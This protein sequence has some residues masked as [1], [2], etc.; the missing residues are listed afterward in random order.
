M[1]IQGDNAWV[2]ANKNVPANLS[3]YGGPY[4][5]AI[6]DSAVQEY[7][8]K[9]GK[10]EF[11]WDAA[12]HIRLGDSQ[13]SLISPWDAYHV[14]SI[15]LQGDGTFVV[16]MR[17]TFAVYK[18]DIKTGKIIWTLGGRHS[19]FK[20]KSGAKFEW[21]HDVRL[22]PGTPLMSVFDDHCCQITGGGTYVAPT[23]DSRGLIL[24][25]NMQAHTVSL[26]DQYYRPSAV[27]PDYMGSIQPL[28]GGNEFVGWGSKPYFSEFTAAGKTILD[29]LLPGPDLSYRATV[30]PWV[31][32]PLTPPSGAV[33]GRTVYASWNGATRVAAWRVLA[34]SDASSLRPV[35]RADRSG[36][37]TPI[38][39]SGGYHAFEVQALNAQG[40]AIGVSKPFTS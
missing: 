32:L 9:T 11:N 23:P 24:K 8:L 33:R 37:E 35:A 22:Y 36:F 3:A 17:N 25:L 18:V 13:E 5:G 19:D 30:Q 1:I 38:P 16:S 27:D 4:N 7:N 10:L 12:K 2:T 20:F 31:G 14:N 21:Q 39:V 40:R 28:P 34:G 29:G 15:D 26:A 6:I